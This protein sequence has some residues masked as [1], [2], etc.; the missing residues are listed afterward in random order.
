MSEG[1]ETPVK[2]NDLGYARS[3]SRREALKLG[4]Q[5]AL[6]KTIEAAKGI[7]AATALTNGVEHVTESENPVLSDA[8][9]ENLIKSVLVTSAGAA[10]AADALEKTTKRRGFLGKL[11]FAASASGFLK[12]STQPGK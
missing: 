4:T 2:V 7:T 9:K 1:R 8:R 11:L 10:L 6:D 12:K 5:V 3:I